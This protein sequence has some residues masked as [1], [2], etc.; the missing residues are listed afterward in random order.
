MFSRAAEVPFVCRDCE[1]SVAAG[2]LENIGD[3][4]VIQKVYRAIHKLVLD[5]SVQEEQNHDRS[6]K[7]RGREAQ[8]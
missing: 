2:P 8:A 3:Q 1:E 4:R 5:I 6:N 7:R